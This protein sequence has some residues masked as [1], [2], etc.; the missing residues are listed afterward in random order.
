MLKCGLYF[1][2]LQMDGFAAMFYNIN[3]LLKNL[4]GSEKVTNFALAFEK[5]PTEGRSEAGTAEAVGKTPK[6]RLT[7]FS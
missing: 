5:H 7:N 3:F 1:G 2:D 4:E 6:K